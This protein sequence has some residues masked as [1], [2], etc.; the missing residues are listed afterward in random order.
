MQKKIGIQQSQWVLQGG[1][2]NE[3]LADTVAAA[4]AVVA[5]G[6]QQ[7]LWG[8]L[9]CNRA[10]GTGKMQQTQWVLL[11]CS[12]DRGGSRDIVRMQGGCG[13]YR[14]WIFVLQVLGCA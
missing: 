4:E 11:G 8:E 2:C 9:R 7:S 3:N 5:A 12:R 6:I 14:A 10:E 13:C 1:M